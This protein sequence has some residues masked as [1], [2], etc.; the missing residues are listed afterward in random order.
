M[1]A[2][3]PASRS[4]VPEA[5]NALSAMEM[6]R[7]ISGGRFTAEAVM[8]ACLERVAA[9]EPEV[10][11]WAALDAEKALAAAR[12]ADRTPARGL[13]HGVPFGVKD[14]IETGELPT[15]MGSPLYE[16]YRPRVDAACVALARAAGALVLG[17]TIT[18]E[19]AG[20]AP[21]HT[22][23]PLALERTP[24]GSSS[25]SAAAVADLMVPVA[26]GTQTGGSILRPASFC[27]VIGFKPT[28]GTF[29]P[30]GVKPAAESFDT[31]GLIARTLD[32][33]E[34]FASVLSN[35]EA[36]HVV[37]ETPPRV[38]IFRTH[39]WDTAQPETVE[40]IEVAAHT[41]GSAGATVIEIPVPAYFERMTAERAVINAYERAQSLAAEWQF[42][43]DAFSP[44]MIATCEKGFAIGRHE[45][46]EA[47]IHVAQYR[48]AAAGLF[49]Q[50]DVLLTPCVPGEAPQGLAYA[51]D[52]RFQEI[53]T[54]LHLPS[55]TLP[56]HRGPN[57]LPVGIQL[58]A[59]HY[60][61][62]L[63][64]GAARWIGRRFGVG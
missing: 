5:L 39:L 57:G 10:K 35:D 14:V 48:R 50:V 29:N 52:P 6:V 15:A 31:V 47:Q 56:T 36:M 43:R 18:A 53:W 38:G 23:N 4:A 3:S 8:R 26:Y 46:V 34:L 32:D 7:G 17:K 25:G 64:L 45:Y 44:Q 12:L 59:A 22:H 61:E 11:A 9:R 33:I 20:S 54:M 40:A 60:C 1:A 28:F 41:L 16:G 19:F 62:T 42:G 58:V 63:L 55:L 21:T 51:G 37:P 49:E 2:S 30:V 27:G 24:G 13:L